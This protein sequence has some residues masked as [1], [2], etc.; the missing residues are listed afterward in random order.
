MPV[1]L[2]DNEARHRGADSRREGDHQ[3][4]DAHGA[5]AAIHGEHQH[6][7]GH[8]HRHQDARACRLHQTTAEQHGEV[9]S[10]TAQ[11]SAHGEQAHGCQEQFPR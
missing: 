2:I 7:H 3:A 8:G 4:E 5:A 10:Q 6:Q 11:Q 1:G 9:M